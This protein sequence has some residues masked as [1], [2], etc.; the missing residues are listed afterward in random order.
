M[1]AKSK[2]RRPTDLSG[3]DST[4]GAFEVEV[5]VLV[6][7]EVLDSLLVERRL[8]KGAKLVILRR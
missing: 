5:P 6:L 4:V 1:N 8:K 2:M 7:V 3:G